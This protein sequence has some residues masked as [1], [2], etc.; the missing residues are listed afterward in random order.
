MAAGS[1]A[2]GRQLPGHHTEYPVVIVQNQ[3]ADFALAAQAH[4]QL[5]SA[6]AQ[7]RKQ[8][9]TGHARAF[10]PVAARCGAGLRGV[11]RHRFV[12]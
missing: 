12:A 2:I 4:A 8:A 7:R 10:G 5:Q 11:G 3:L 1:A 6:G 9:G